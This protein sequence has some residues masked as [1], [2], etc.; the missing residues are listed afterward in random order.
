MAYEKSI[1]YVYY[2]EILNAHHLQQ[3]ISANAPKAGIEFLMEHK[4]RSTPQQK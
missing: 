2:C 1:Q 3:D 4:I